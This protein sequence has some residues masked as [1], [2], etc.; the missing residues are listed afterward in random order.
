MFTNFLKV[1]VKLSLFLFFF[2]VVKGVNK[3]AKLLWCQTEIQT[4][5]LYSVYLEC[6]FPLTKTIPM[7][8]EQVAAACNAEFLWKMLK[9]R[10]CLFI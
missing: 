7:G 1:I 2:R 8:Y 5:I 4:Y 3:V 10:F 6:L 9:T